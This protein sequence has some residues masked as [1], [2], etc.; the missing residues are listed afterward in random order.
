MKIRLCL[1]L[2]IVC[3][4]FALAAHSAEPTLV[5]PFEQVK[6]RI[7]EICVTELAEYGKPT[8]E[9]NLDSNTAKKRLIVEFSVTTQKP[10]KSQ[11]KAQSLA[12]EI[13]SKVNALLENQDYYRNANFINISCA[14]T[15]TANNGEKV[16]VTASRKVQR[17]GAVAPASGSAYRGLGSTSPVTGPA[18]LFGR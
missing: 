12:K 18:P 4:L 9:W 3:A 1:L 10:I 2:T 11:E 15:H 14:V 16:K 8:I 6:K 13:T 5:I 17:P 7:S